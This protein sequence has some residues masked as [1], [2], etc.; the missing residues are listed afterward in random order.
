VRENDAGQVFVANLTTATLESA[1][2]F[3]AQF[4]CVRSAPFRSPR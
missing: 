2:E 1:P 3:D 4:A